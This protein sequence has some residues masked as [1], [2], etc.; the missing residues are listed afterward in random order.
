MAN[1]VT[2]NAVNAAM[3]FRSATEDAGN[4]IDNLMS[5]YGWTMPGPNGEYSTIAAGDAFDPNNVMQFSET[6]KAVYD[7][8]KARTMGGQIS[9]K[10][11]FA[12]ILRGGATEE[13]QAVQDVRNRG[14]MQGG[15]ARQARQLA[16]DLA[17]QKT[18]QASG[19]LFNAIFGQY[20][21]VGRAYGNLNQQ[22]V[23][24]YITSGQT[25][26]QYV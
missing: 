23:L 3:A 2:G 14:I 26:A 25:G 18:G 1:E 20:G 5:Q 15:L 7:P 22:Q 21:N 17:T 9:T 24:D 10:G 12:D 11:V 8:T 4:F 19:E 16:E 6:G 13:A